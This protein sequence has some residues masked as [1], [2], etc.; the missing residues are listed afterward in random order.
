MLAFNAERPL[1]RNNPKLRRA[2]NYALDRKALLGTA[3]GPIALRSTDQYLPYGIPGFRDSDIYPLGGP[4][5]ARARALARGNLR[6]RKA[7]MYTT[8][9]APAMALAQAVKQQ[10]AAIGLELEIVPI[11][12]HVASA[13]YLETLARGGE[14]DL[15]LV[16]WTPNIPDPHAYLNQLLE[17]QHL[18]GRTLTG[19]RSRVA[20]RELGQAARRLQG[21]ARDDAYARLDAL[22]ARDYAP[23]AALDVVNEVT[24]VSNR[25]GCMVL[26]PVLDLAVACLK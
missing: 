18:D 14:W 5:L 16:L 13:A 6:Q 3:G 25:V 9:V 4:D 19:F 12:L 20:S 7:V 26:R 24:L 8:S 21:R 15:A 11:T 23:L 2:I 17:A 10:L 22:L 1:F